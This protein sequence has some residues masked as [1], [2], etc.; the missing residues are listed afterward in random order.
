M[1]DGWMD[2]SINLTLGLQPLTS[3]MIP[4]SFPY[5]SLCSSS[6][7]SEMSHNGER[8]G[9]ES[10]RELSTFTDHSHLQQ[11]DVMND[12]NLWKQTGSSVRSV[13]AAPIDLLGRHHLPKLH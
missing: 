12:I 10:F 11:M 4:S 8:K 13:N 5:N 2:Q 9:L 6:A 1:D 7:S 3:I